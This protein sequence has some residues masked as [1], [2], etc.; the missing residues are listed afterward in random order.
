MLELFS[1][2][3]LADTTSSLSDAAISASVDAAAAADAFIDGTAQ[4]S[5]EDKK[6]VASEKE[7]IKDTVSSILETANLNVTNARSELVRLLVVEAQKKAVV[8]AL[9]SAKEDAE[10]ALVKPAENLC[11]SARKIKSGTIK[12]I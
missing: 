5:V 10:S 11:F 4:K 3:A 12:F 1:E 2:G 6:V 9:E 8:E 7:G